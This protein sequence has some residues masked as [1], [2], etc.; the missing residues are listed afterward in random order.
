MKPEFDFNA[1]IKSTLT[2]WFTPEKIER[3]R[4]TAEL[5]MWMKQDLDSQPS[6]RDQK[7]K[8]ND[9]AKYS[10]AL[11]KALSNHGRSAKAEIS[12]VIEQSGFSHREMTELPKKLG[13]FSKAIKKRVS[14]RDTQARRKNHAQLV[15]MINSVTS[16]LGMTASRSDPSPF[17]ET[18]CA[19]FTSIGL[20][21][22]DRSITEFLNDRSQKI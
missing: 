11:S 13:V 16:E 1:E 22:P 21:S 17:Y 19:I 20:A 5:Y 3:L 6:W 4:F 12:T 10:G 18:C 7:E 15:S 9:I 2:K 14:Y 8:L